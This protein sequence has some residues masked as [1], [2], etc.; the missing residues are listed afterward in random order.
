MAL[1]VARHVVRP[2]VRPLV[3]A[4]AFLTR[5][6]VWS[7]PLRD[8][9]LG[10]SVSFFPVVGLVLG[11]GLTGLASLLAG[12]LPP[13]LAAVLLVALLAALTGGLHLDGVAD[14]FDALGG[15]RGDRQRMLDIMKDSRIGAHG[16][17]ALV[18]VL[19]AKVA[20]AAE[21][22][23]R[24]DLAGLLVFPA[25]ARWSVTPAIVFHPYA[26]DEGTGRAFNGEARPREVIVATALLAL[27]LAAVGPRLFVPAA[28]ALAAATLFALWLRRRLG[29]LTGD[30]YGASIEIAELVALTIM[31]TLR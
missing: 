20:A 31:G 22:V 30:V 25:I 13:T 12:V 29:G 1:S 26:R 6:P 23:A 17:A 27:A 21:L 15:G 24:R 3:A 7:G 9:D 11:L 14:V 5:V 16:A 19:L 18:L 8:E 10:R 28:G 2:V 4:F